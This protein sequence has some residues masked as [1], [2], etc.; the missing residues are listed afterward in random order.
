[1]KAVFVFGRRP[2][3]GTIC[4]SLRQ[5]CPC[6]LGTIYNS[7][8]RF[9]GR[10]YTELNTHF[11]CPC[12]CSVTVVSYIYSW[13][14]S[15]CTPLI[16]VF[17]LQKTVEVAAAGVPKIPFCWLSQKLCQQIRARNLSRCLPSQWGTACSK[18]PD[19]KK[20]SSH[21]VQSSRYNY[22]RWFYWE[23]LRLWI[24]FCLNGI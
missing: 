16:Y 24:S 12:E 2:W 13:I 20:V 9:V 1:M 4:L 21:W 17:R 23:L 10:E 7:V 11:S 5:M 3:A 19:L 6:I 15:V 22:E 8:L 18:N 14:H